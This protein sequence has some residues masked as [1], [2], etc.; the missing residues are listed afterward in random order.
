MKASVDRETERTRRRYDHSARTYDLF[1]WLGERFMANRLRQRLWRR[2]TPG[3]VL[4]VGVGTGANI[5]LH[6]EG[7]VVTSIDLSPRMLERA[8][9]V[10]EGRTRRP[11][12]RVGDV[13]KLSAS[14]TS[15][16]AAAATFVFCSVPDP[17][18]GLRELRR[19]VKPGGRILLLEH[20]RIDLP[21]VGRLMDLL[22]PIAVRLSG[23][24][25][26]RRTT[27]S[28]RRSGLEL[29]TEER[30]GPFGLLRLIEARVPDRQTSEL[31][32][33]D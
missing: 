18:R 6:P 32:E 33:V 22:D 5:P 21:L 30:H 9:A 24:H 19:V 20:V 25:I 31:G 3:R 12:L 23:A 8:R 16:D 27:E 11:D 13:Q 10:R 1:N 15:F 26:N 29:V 14:D 4:E 2:I 28:V 17:V 7:A